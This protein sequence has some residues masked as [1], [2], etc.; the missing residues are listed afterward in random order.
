MARVAIPPEE[1]Q[2]EAP[3]AMT[4][5]L[6]PELYV[7]RKRWGMGTKPR[8]SHQALIVEAIKTYLGHGE[9]QVHG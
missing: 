8:K 5:E 9:N 6:D 7:Q 2:R 3:I 4:V 1:K